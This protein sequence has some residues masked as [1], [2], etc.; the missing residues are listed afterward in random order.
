MTP[1]D[2]IELEAI[3]RLKY[4]YFRCVDQKRWDELATL[5]THDV[6]ARYGGGK[7]EL[8]GRDAVVDWLRTTMAA[9][10]LHTSHRG[11]HPEIDLAGEEAQGTWAFDDTVIE[12]GFEVTI[13]GAGFYEDRY[14]KV[15]GAWRI[16]ETGYKRTFEELQPRDGASP[17]SLT[18]SWW[19]TD[20][21]SSLM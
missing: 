18:A 2:L 14:R 10:T 20:G 12:T 9:E 16:C 6:V 13:R 17:P 8:S 11:G 21:T 19:S 15:D 3:K 1:E 7:V 5:L 4:A